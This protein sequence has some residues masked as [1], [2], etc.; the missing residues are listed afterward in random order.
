MHTRSIKAIMGLE[1]DDD[2]PSEYY[3]AHDQDFIDATHAQAAYSTAIG[4]IIYAVGQGHRYWGTCN[5]TALTYFKSF[6][7]PQPKGLPRTP[8]SWDRVQG[9]HNINKTSTCRKTVLIRVYQSLPSSPPSNPPNSPN[10]GTLHLYCS[11]SFLESLI[12]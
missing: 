7:S 3:T 9:L 6:I 1:Q 8:T 11:C 4:N 12:F 10:L 5:Q 2:E